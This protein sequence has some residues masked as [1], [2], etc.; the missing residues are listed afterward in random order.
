MRTKIIVNPVAGRGRAEK[1]LA[2]L[3]AYLDRYGVSADIVHTRAK[4]DAI[5]LAR[6]AAREGYARVVAMGGDGTVGEVTAGLLRAMEEGYEAVLGILPAGSGNDYAYAVGIPTRLE[7]ACRRLVDGQVRC[8]DVV[9]V[10][11]DGRTYYFNNTVGIGLDADVLLETHKLKRIRGFLLYFTA[12]LR[13]LAS[14]GRWPYP[15]RVTVDGETLPQ[16][17]V[18]LVTACNGPRVAGGFYLTPDARPD[19]GQLDVIV[20]EQLSRLRVASFI[21]R[22]MRGT[23]VGAKPVHICRARHVVI[24]G[25]RGLPGHMDG[26]VLCTAGRRIEIEILPGRLKV[27][28]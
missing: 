3:Y 2:G 22:V 19:D 18:T 4:G 25:L 11:A 17:A 28:C 8:V 13:V 6:Q 26:E 5:Q 24:E 21:T 9:R 23:H 15:V 27:W 16:Q 1:L 14:N 20:A 10:T 7:P 12:L